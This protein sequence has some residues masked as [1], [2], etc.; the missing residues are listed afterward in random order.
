MDRV[1]DDLPAAMRDATLNGG[2][3]FVLI[4]AGQAWIES[5]THLKPPEFGHRAL[6]FPPL[7]DMGP[8]AER[9]VSREIRS[10]VAEGVAAHVDDPDRQGRVSRGLSRRALRDPARRLG[11]PDAGDGAASGRG[12][13]RGGLRRMGAGWAPGGQSRPSS[14]A[15]SPMRSSPSRVWPPISMKRRMLV[16]APSVRSNWLNRNASS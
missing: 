8:I 14:P 10:A 2:P 6:A 12:S 4:P 3:R 1:D 13:D 7:L 9:P 5:E 11:A 16:L 15:S